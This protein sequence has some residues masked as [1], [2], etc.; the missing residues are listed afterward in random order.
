MLVPVYH[1]IHHHTSKVGILN[2]WNRVLL[3]KLTGFQLVK[4][5]PSFYET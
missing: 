3:D 2:P 5:F 4:K 1:T